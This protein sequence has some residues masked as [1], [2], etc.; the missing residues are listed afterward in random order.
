MSP[1]LDVHMSVSQIRTFLSACNRN[2]IQKKIAMNKYIKLLIIPVS[3]FLANCTSGQNSPADSHPGS[4]SVKAGRSDQ[5]GD[6]KDTAKTDSLP[7]G[8]KVQQ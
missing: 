5:A 3:L 7:A 6:K 1:I 2:I 8:D 4:G